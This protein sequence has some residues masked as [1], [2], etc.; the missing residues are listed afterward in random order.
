MEIIA[1]TEIG[2]VREV[3][4]DCVQFLQKNDHECLAVLCDGMGGHNA[5]EVASLLACED[6]IAQYEIHDDFLDE[7]DIQTWM[8]EAIH[9]ANRVIQ[10]KSV[11]NQELEGMGTTVV[12]AL[13]KDKVLYVSHVGD[14]RAY[15]YD[16][17]HLV[18]L[19][20]DDT[21]VNALLDAGSISLDEA[22][23]HPQKNILIQAVG[24]SEI[25]RISFRKQDIHDGIVL[26][27]SDGLY[28]SLFDEQMEEILEKDEPLEDIGNQLMVMANTFGGKDNIG[29]ILI[30]DKGVVKDE[31]NK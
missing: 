16:G 26:L 18:Q 27:C 3:N 24:V 23:F 10:E 29:F 25:L 1:K 20:K 31:P 2:N 5:G 14:S 21:L 8:S 19:T 11:S 4:Q 15:Y 30:H 12:L 9:H 7:Q 6:I 13:V 28:N 22:Q 17:H